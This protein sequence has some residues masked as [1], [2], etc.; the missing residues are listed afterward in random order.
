MDYTKLADEAF[1]MYNSFIRAGF[2]FNYAFELTK[3]CVKE[4]PIFK[5]FITEDYNNYI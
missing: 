5:D 4:F 2:S 1:K 3:F